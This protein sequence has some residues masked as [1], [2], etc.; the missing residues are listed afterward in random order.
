MTFRD[1][2]D[3]PLATAILLEALLDFRVRSA[4]AMPVTLVHDNHV[5]EVEHDDFLQ[6][7]AAA[8][9]RVHHQHGKI[10]NS[11]FLKRHCF[12]TSSDG[13]NENVVETKSSEQREA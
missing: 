3:E 7:Q 9:I 12:L 4:G 11:I 2:V 13:F 8:V 1:G 5:G 10:D 6:L